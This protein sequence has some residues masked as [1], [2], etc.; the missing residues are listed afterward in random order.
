MDAAR[1]ADELA[2][3]HGARRSLDGGTPVI[4]PASSAPAE[5]TLEEVVALCRRLRFKY[6]REQDKR[7][8]YRTC[9]ALGPGRAVANLLLSEAEGRERSTVEAKRR[10]RTFPQAR[11][12]TAGSRAA[13]RSRRPHSGR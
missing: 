8:S 11:R 12:P 1:I 13:R 2:L 3:S 10:R 9:P 6:V 7:S 4:R 5:A